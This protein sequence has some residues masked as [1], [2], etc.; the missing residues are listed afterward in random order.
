MDD[1]TEKPVVCPQRGAHEFQSRFSREHKHFI[2]E[3][4]KNHDRTGKPV[5]CLQPGAQQFVI[6]HD[7]T[8][9]ELSLGSRSFWNRV[10]DQVR[11]RQ[12]RSSMNDTEDSK[13]H[14]VIWGMFMSVTL[15]SAMFMGKNYLN[16]CH[17]I[18]NTKDLTMKQMFDIS[19][20]LMSEQ[21]EISGL[22]T[23]GWESSSWK[24]LSLI[25]DEQINN[26]Q[27]TKVYV[28][29][30]SVLC[31][32]KM[33]ENPRSNIAREQRL[34]WFKSSPEY[35]TLDRIDGE[36][37][38]FELNIFPGFNTLQLSQED[39]E[40]L[41]KDGSYPC[42]CSMT[43]HGDQKT[44]RENAIQMLN[45]FLYLQEDSEQ[46]NGHFSVISEDSPQGEWDKMAEKMMATLAESGHPVF[47]ATSPLSR[48][49]LKS[50]GGGKLSI[51]YTITTVFRTITSANQ[52]SL[53]GAVAE[54]CEEYESY[55]V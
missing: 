5:V 1:R 51:H 39:Q 42:G 6:E 27:R 43:S 52:L 54:I 12:K 53:Y 26:L 37:I 44:T 50:K 19:A 9:S 10:K 25:G 46:D 14:S 49:Q 29:S 18:A 45:S 2:L 16:N 32:G 48:G 4:E 7:E 21:D 17:S 33:N 23:I 24:Y 3:E 55:H 13:E 41:L 47:R 11:K 36:P 15:E 8:E 20:K 38:T 34:E 22:E 40:L 30:D 28:F 31:L 35:R